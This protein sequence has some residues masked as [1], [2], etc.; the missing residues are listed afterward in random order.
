MNKTENQKHNCT[1]LCYIERNGQYLMLHR[2][3]K[4]ADANFGKWIGVGGKFEEGESFE[5][6]Y[7]RASKALLEVVKNEKFKATKILKAIYKID[8]QKLVSKLSSYI[9]LEQ[10]DENFEVEQ[11]AKKVNRKG[12]NDFD[13]DKLNNLKKQNKLSNMFNE[14]EMLD[15]YD[16]ST[17]RG[18]RGKKKNIKQENRTKQK[19]FKLTEI[20]IPETITVKDLA[21]EMKITSGDVIKKLLSLGIM[22]TINN[23]IDLYSY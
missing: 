17:E 3:S 6:V 23:D 22:A 20:T 10:F 11:K 9:G 15:Y 8:I 21:S 12:N 5:E 14:G 19:I 1:T 18:R 16:L 4:D 2:V 7:N 13:S